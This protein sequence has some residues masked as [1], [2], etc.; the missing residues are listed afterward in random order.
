MTATAIYA[1][2]LREAGRTKQLAAEVRRLRA[3]NERIVTL[4]KD[5]DEV[6][7]REKQVR[8]LLGVSPIQVPAAAKL[9]GSPASAPGGPNRLPPASKETLPTLW[10][11]NGEISRAFTVS[12]IR[13]HEGLDIAGSA[14]A[15]VLAAGGGTVIFAGPDSVFGN[16][17]RID[18]GNGYVTVY[19]HNSRLAVSMGQKVN[20]GQTIAYVGNTGISSAPHLH[21]EVRRDGQPLDPMTLIGPAGARATRSR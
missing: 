14:G 11:V 6:S 3:D 5:L 20:R 4:A 12:S 21:F 13:R 17:V 1:N 8:A 10:P 2:L 16:L 15:P 18:H 19:G 7:A 9:E